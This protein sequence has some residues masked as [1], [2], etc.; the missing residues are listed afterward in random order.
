MARQILI[1]TLN[2]RAYTYHNDG[3][4]VAE[5]Q[6][7]K[8]PVPRGGDGWLRGIVTEVDVPAPTR[9]ETKGIIGPV[10]AEDE[11]ERGGE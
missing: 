8:L 9:F 6:A 11:A 7:V 10:T 2:G 5:G 1:A 4:P 3:E